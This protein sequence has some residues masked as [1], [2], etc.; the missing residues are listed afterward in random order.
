MKKE[1]EC[2]RKCLIKLRNCW[3]VAAETD[4]L[5]AMLRM[6]Q[7]YAIAKCL[8]VNLKRLKFCV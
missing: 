8:L 6:I 4:I 2:L 3:F 5:F 7:F 1:C